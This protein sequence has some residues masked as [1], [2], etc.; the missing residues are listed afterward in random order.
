MAPRGRAPVVSDSPDRSYESSPDPLNASINSSTS[1]AR[2]ARRRMAQTP[3]ASTSPSKQNRQPN[4]SE[5]L[6]HLSSPSKSMVMNTGRPGGASP[7]RIKVTVEAEPEN[8]SDVENTSPSVR[9]VERRTTTTVPLKD[10]DASSPPKRRGRPRKSDVAGSAKSRRAGTPVK[11]RRRRSSVNASMSEPT[12]LEPSST[13]SP[14]KRRGR[15]RKNVQPEPESEPQPEPDQEPQPDGESEYEPNHETGLEHEQDEDPD[16]EQLEPTNIPCADVDDD[17]ADT[18]IAAETTVIPLIETTLATPQGT[19]VPVPVPVLKS[20]SLM[21]PR[22]QFKQRPRSYVEEYEEAVNFGTPPETDLRRRLKE[23]KGTP[24]SKAARKSISTSDDESAIDTPSGTDEE[25]APLEVDARDQQRLALEVQLETLR[26]GGR[27]E[28]ANGEI[29]TYAFDE[30]ETRMP[31]DTT[32]WESENFSMISVDSLPS[33]GGLLSSNHQKSTGT[34]ATGATHPLTTSYLN[35]PAASSSKSAEVSSQQ[36]Q[37]SPLQRKTSTVAPPPEQPQENSRERHETP[38]MDQ[39]SPSQPPALEPAQFAPSESPQMDRAVTAGVALQGLVDPSRGTPQTKNAQGGSLEDLFRGFSD[40]TRKELQAGLRLGQQLAMR[41]ENNDSSPLSRSPRPTLPDASVKCAFVKHPET[42]LITPENQ[43]DQNSQLPPPATDNVNDEYP[44]LVVE[45]QQNTHLVSPELS[46]DEMS[47][48]NI[49]AAGSETIEIKGGRTLLTATNPQ[50][51]QIRGPDVYVETRQSETGQVVTAYR[52]NGEQI[53]GSEIS[54]VADEREEVEGRDNEPQSTVTA[55]EQGE[56]YSDIWQEEASRSMTDDAGSSEV[57][58]RRGPNSRKTRKGKSKTP[59]ALPNGGPIEPPRAK[60]PRTRRPKFQYSDE[61]EEEQQELDVASSRVKSAQESTK[62][63]QMHRAVQDSAMRDVDGGVSEISEQSGVFFHPEVLTTRPERERKIQRIEDVSMSLLLDD[64]E[65][66]VPVS[67]PVLQTQ[68]S[69]AS[70]YPSPKSLSPEGK[71][72]SN[73]PAVDEKK[74]ASLPADEGQSLN[75]SSPAPINRTPTTSKPNPF[76][77]TPPRFTPRQFTPARSSPLRQELRGSDAESSFDESSLPVSSPFRTQVD[78]SNISI[79]SHEQQLLQEMEGVT[80]SS[81]VRV[82]READARAEAYGSPYRTLHEIE[83]VTEVSRSEKLSIVMPSSPPVRLSEAAGH[84]SVLGDGTRESTLLDDG[85]SFMA[86][87]MDS[88]ILN[89]KRKHVRIALEDERTPTSSRRKTARHVSRPAKKV[90]VIASA[91]HVEEDPTSGRSGSSSSSSGGILNRL[92][93][94]LPGTRGTSTAQATS[95]S[96]SSPRPPTH[97]VASR[98]APGLPKAN[99]W[100]KTHYKTLDTLFHLH[101]KDATLFDPVSS[102]VNAA[103][104]DHFL[105]QPGNDKFLGAIYTSWGYSVTITEPLVVIAAVYLCNILVLK[106]GAEY[107]KRSGRALERGD[108]GPGRAGARI[109]AEAVMERLATVVM[110]R[111]LRRDER[112]GVKVRKEGRLQV[113]WAGE[114]SLM[115]V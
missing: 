113:V 40:G 43:E 25:Q 5:R 67:S 70:R 16:A 55:Q 84:S 47:W 10:G 114:S 28:S 45:E 15:P 93:S 26:R 20:T 75:L 58:N 41:R 91:P 30:G 27:D 83:E 106:D 77:D 17:H 62:Q 53:I 2:P 87:P 96:S 103:L 102:A 107:E 89:S 98:F 39:R 36:K 78:M 97:P 81:I 79:A 73:P 13:A 90:P 57:Q 108:V 21:P 31:D 115:G 61:A 69:G 71:I 32:L 105:S 24:H 109:T 60:L 68:S 23:R 94:T 46:D 7:W 51:E 52:S 59:D 92:G 49:I 8:S 12:V 86:E 104:L 50:G 11:P 82:R 37:Y 14:K 19:P 76:K 9:H 100:T 44:T 99:P 85:D 33:C 65:A 110:G 95:P 22:E 72:S 88:S 3:L 74:Q 42:R 54:V 64:G 111:A 112:R 34:L 29:D 48:S 101:R 1:K 4:V 18:E 66:S 35:I 6:M 38:A 56:D 63:N 80:D